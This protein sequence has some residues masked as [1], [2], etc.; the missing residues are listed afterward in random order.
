M[1]TVQKCPFSACTVAQKVA[2]PIPAGERSYMRGK[3]LPMPTNHRT[4]SEAG[5][6]K[7]QPHFKSRLLIFY[8]FTC[9][10]H[11]LLSVFSCASSGKEEF[12]LDTEICGSCDIFRHI[13]ANQ[14]VHVESP[15]ERT[16]GRS[17]SFSAWALAPW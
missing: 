3:C 15:S 16:R 14:L 17:T 9:F 2:L 5:P 10:S 6:P 7:S 1:P 12:F 11:F 13:A 4:P 8:S